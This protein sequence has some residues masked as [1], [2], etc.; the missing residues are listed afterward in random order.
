MPK[1]K[2]ISYSHLDKRTTF[3]PQQQLNASFCEPM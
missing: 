3:S 1:A 2:I